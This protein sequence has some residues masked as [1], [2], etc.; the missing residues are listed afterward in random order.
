MALREQSGSM[1]Q[2]RAVAEGYTDGDGGYSAVGLMLRNLGVKDEIL[3]QLKTNKP[4]LEMESKGFPFFL[5]KI[6]RDRADSVCADIEKYNDQGKQD[7]CFIL[8]GYLLRSYEFE[9][10]VHVS[11]ADYL[12]L[13]LAVLDRIEKSEGGKVFPRPLTK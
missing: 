5:D 11:E 1:L 13:R 3:S 10:C 2:F 6:K 9:L 4:F 12:R 7:L 8:M